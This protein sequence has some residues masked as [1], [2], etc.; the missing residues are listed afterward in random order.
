MEIYAQ[1]SRAPN[2][3]RKLRR[4][5]HSI[6]NVVC[7]ICCKYVPSSNLTLS[8]SLDLAQDGDNRFAL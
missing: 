4:L 2:V 7:C 6:Y 5:G 8:H 3:G 1:R